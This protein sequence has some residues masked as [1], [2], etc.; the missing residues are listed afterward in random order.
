MLHN[1]AGS[2]GSDPSGLV[3]A[4]DG[5]FYGTASGGTL[6]DGVIFRI[7]SSGSFTDL[8]NFTG[9][10]DGSDPQN[11]LIQGTDGS[12]YGANK[13]GVY[14]Y[15]PSGTPEI[16][17]SFSYPQPLGAISQMTQGTDGMLYL[18][19]SAGG[20][21]DCGSVSKLS[22]QG[23][24]QWERDFGSPGVCD[25]YLKTGWG[26]NAPVIQ[27]SDGNLYST[28]LGGGAYD[29]G[30]VF[31]L[32]SDTGA[33]A[34][35]LN[36]DFTNG[37]LSEAGL[38]QG[39]DGNLYGVSADGGAFPY[40]GVIYQ[41]TL[42]GAYT[43]LANVA[44]RQED[45]PNWSLLQH[46]SGTFYGV[47]LDGGTHEYGAVYSFDNNLGPFVTF[48][49]SEGSVGSTVQILGQDLTGAT[50]VTFNG[51]PAKGFSVVSATYLTAVVPV[52]ATTGTVSITTPTQVLK[53][54]KR[55]TIS[56]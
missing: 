8:Y 19:I 42:P 47:N 33:M 11:S 43:F 15:E 20:V 28:N 30:T 50:Q 22:L 46:T 31:R 35:L 38:V 48:V 7:S 18:V 3:L 17:Y 26:P 37:G 34:I 23:A 24:V 51:V 14:S 40:A 55:F 16:F 5:N 10:A 21:Y 2:D 41:L 36:F 13:T 52:G 39:N 45:W 6:G 9:G 1:F 27:A 53:S 29:Y 54:N 12:F 32:Y 49:Q 4:T 25:E 44:D 56:Q